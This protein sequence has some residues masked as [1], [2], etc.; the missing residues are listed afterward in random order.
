M[1]HFFLFLLACVFSGLASPV[2][3]QRSTGA[4]SPARPPISVPFQYYPE[5]PS[6]F[7]L[8]ADSMM[9]NLDKSQITTNVLYDRVAGMAALDVFNR[10]YNDPDTSSVNHFMQ[11]YYEMNVAPYGL[12]LN[13]PNRQILR[14]NARYSSERGV[15]LI[16]ALRYRFNSIDSNAVR[17]NQLRWSAG[18][19]STLLDVAGRTGSPYLER[20]VVVGA[21]LVDTVRQSTVSF[22]LDPASIFTNKGSA[23]TSA[24]IDFGDGAGARNCSVGLELNVSYNSRGRKVLRYTFGYADGS[25]YTTYSS[26]YVNIPAC[27]NCRTQATNVAPCRTAPFAATTAFN[28]L[29]GQEDLSYYYSSDKPCTAVNVTK[30]VII[31]DGFDHN[32]TRKGPDI[33]NTYLY[34]KDA[35]NTEQNLG[36]ELRD[37]GYDVVIMNEPNVYTTVK[38]GLFQYSYISVHGGSDY[39]ERNGL[40]LVALIQ[41]LNRQLQAAGS[42]EQVVVVGPSMGGQI[43]RYAL[44]YMEANNIPHNTRLFVSLDSPH[45]GANIPIGLQN[46]VKYFADATQD[47]QLVDGLA[48][49]DSPAS[50]EMASTFY[51]QGSGF[52]AHPDRTTFMNTVTSFRSN[53]LP[54]NLRRV[55]I[56]NGALNGSRQ[57]DQYGRFI[58]DQ[59]Q[60]FLLEQRGVPSGGLTGTLVR[61][62]F[63]IGLVG[64]LVTTASG[65]VWYAPGQGQQAKVLRAYKLPSEHNYYATGPANSCGLDG[66]PGGYRN[67]FSEI[68]DGNNS[69][70]LFQKRNFYSVRDKAVF[71]PMLSALAYT[72]SSY[73]NCTSVNGL[74]LV[75]NGTTPFDAYYGPATA[76]EPHIQLTPGNVDFI[77]NE[78]LRKTPAPVFTDTRYSM[79]P[80]GATLGVSIK[81]E[82]ATSR[83]G[84]PQSATSYYWSAYG[85]QIISGQGTPNVTIQSSTATTAYLSVTATRQGYASSTSSVSVVVAPRSEAHGTYTAMGAYNSPLNTVNYVSPGEVRITISDPYNNYTF[86]ANPPSIQVYGGGQQAGFR[87]EAGQGVQ[88]T[89]SSGGPCGIVGNFAFT[90]RNPYLIQSSPNPVDEELTVVA[91]QQNILATTPAAVT[92]DQ[93]R[94]TAPP[95]AVEL[96]NNFGRRVKTMTSSKGKAV[97][98]VRDLPSGLY[99]LRVG[100]GPEATTEHIQ[101]TH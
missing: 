14:D 1:K 18:V 85:V 30:P 99:N 52:A 15:V 77:R 5:T 58:N 68:A 22:L 49:V 100:E 42:T 83:P 50:R 33:F 32:D 53:G 56:T 79:C 72:P 80:G 57:L 91:T 98:N 62:L 43:A 65:R 75:C 28:G 20:E 19:G 9:A 88:I 74:N 40:A 46:F 84:Q 64:R 26:I 71:I 90:I 6:G 11:A 31:I 69:S 16:G 27:A 2:L 3:A 67:F 51:S 39:L 4:I 97:L 21:A 12:S 89:A 54:A 92:T 47:A 55:A 73:N 36:V 63:P 29:L 8:H 61:I 60:A 10:S 23:L 93:A 70:G 95:F 59:D 13:V 17:N 44:S 76:S 37:A 25:Q 86:T 87:L 78:I 24:S 35:S 45:N 7:Q 38:I 96:Y 66:T 34:Y 81:S 41:E 101:I 82:C 94:T 48:Q